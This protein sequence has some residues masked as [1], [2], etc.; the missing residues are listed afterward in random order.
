VAAPWLSLGAAACGCVALALVDPTERQV[1]P[2]CPF[3]A[4]TGWW[5]PFCGGT[6]AVSQLVRGELASAVRFNALLFVSLPL[7]A[8]AW[9]VW[10]MPG[11]WSAADHVARVVGSS[12]TFWWSAAAFAVVF[13]VVRNVAPFDAWLRYPGS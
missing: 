5:C 2:A 10:A 7:L 8:L 4:M 9:W 3:R 11:R 12:R 13:V 1:T 6:R